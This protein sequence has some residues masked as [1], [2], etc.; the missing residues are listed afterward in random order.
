MI[1]ILL[2]V[3]LWLA[4]GSTLGD[5]YPSTLTS[6]SVSAASLDA[7]TKLTTL[8]LSATAY[9]CD[10]VLVQAQADAV[11]ELTLTKATAKRTVQVR[12]WHDGSLSSAA[13]VASWQ[14]SGGSAQGTVDVTISATLSGSGATQ[15]INLVVNAATTGWT[16]GSFRIPMAKIPQ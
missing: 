11:W 8:T 7:L 2:A 12:V 5:G 13:T 1:W 4:W 14:V 3:F 6:K 9:T 15:A 10:S 16:A